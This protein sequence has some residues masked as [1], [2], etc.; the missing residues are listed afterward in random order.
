LATDPDLHTVPWYSYTLPGRV[1][2]RRAVFSPTSPP[3]TTR[4][5]Q[6]VRHETAHP[7][8]ACLSPARNP[9][10]GTPPAPAAPRGGDCGR[11]P[12]RYYATTAVLA[13]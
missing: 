12:G 9:N 11:D 8:G 6:G 4:M 5:P 3:C 1:P 13:H 7:V 2:A 10:H